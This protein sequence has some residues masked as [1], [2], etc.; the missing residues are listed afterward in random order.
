MGWNS[1]QVNMY[2]WDCPDRDS[3]FWSGRSPYLTEIEPAPRAYGK[4]Y[5]NEPFKGEYSYFSE[6]KP[7]PSTKKYTD[8]YSNKKRFR[9]YAFLVS[10]AGKTSMDEVARQVK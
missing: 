3:W 4:Q 9:E 10:F 8:K 7:D 5:E 2:Q 1:M 6:D